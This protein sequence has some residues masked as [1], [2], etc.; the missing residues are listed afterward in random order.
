M[1]QV[2]LG[3]TASVNAS[4][5]E[6]EHD[7]NWLAQDVAEFSE[8]NYSRPIASADAK[9]SDAPQMAGPYNINLAALDASLDQVAAWGPQRVLSHVQGLVARLYAGLPA[10]C[11]PSSPLSPAQRGPFGCFVADGEGATAEPL[12]GFEAGADRRQP[13]WRHHPRRAASSQRQR[14]YRPAP[15][16]GGRLGGLEPPRRR[17]ACVLSR[18]C[19]TWGSSCRISPPPDRAGLQ[20]DATFHTWKAKYGVMEVSES[21]RLRALEDENAKLKKLLAKAML[22]NATLRDV[23]A[24]KW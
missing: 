2:S 14:R 10:S 21:R 9:R 23:A 8:L 20:R 5:V 12:R 18:G 16:R 4:H 17:P 19:A 24:R 13:S 15:R 3:G 11:R 6:Q 7:W 22:D 1:I